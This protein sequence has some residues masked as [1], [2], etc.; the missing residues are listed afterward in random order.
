MRDK[1]IAI[2]AGYDKECYG[3]MN[4]PIFQTTAYEFRDSL[5]AAN[6]FEL[7]EMGQIYTRIN[8]PT[9]EIFEKRVAELEGG[10]AGL[11]TA[12]GT[13][14]IF[15]TFANVAEVGDN[16]VVAKQSYGGTLTMAA[17]TLKRFGIEARFFDIF[18]LEELESLIDDKTKKFKF[19]F[20]F[21][22]GNC[23]SSN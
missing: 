16:I 5:H 19:P 9:N 22:E 20:F 21:L 2:R 17:H 7:K 8:N 10:E 1:T 13:A 23:K 11:T 6:L 4:V 12:S 14:S 18:N 15:Y 3:A